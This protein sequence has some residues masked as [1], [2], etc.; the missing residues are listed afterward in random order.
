VEN[1][2]KHINAAQRILKIMF[3]KINGLQ[4]TLL[5]DKPHIESTENALQIFH[6]EGNHW[7]CATTIGATEKKVLVCSKTAG[8]K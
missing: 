7:V 3:L 1:S 5:Q 2:D 6:I 8:R 4:L